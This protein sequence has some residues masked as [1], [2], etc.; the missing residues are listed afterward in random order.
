MDHDPGGFQLQAV[1]IGSPSCGMDDEIC[2][3]ADLRSVQR[4]S[5]H[6]IP[7]VP[8]LD[9][10]DGCSRL[11]IDAERLEPFHQP[12]DE[13]GVEVLEHPVAVLQDCDLR[14]RQCGDV[15]EL[16]SD[17]AAADQDDA[18]RQGFQREESLV[19]NHVLFAGNVQLDRLGPRCQYDVFCFDGLPGNL[20]HVPSRELRSPVEGVDALFSIGRLLPLR[21]GVREGALERHQLGPID[22][23]VADDTVAVHA[24]HLVD[25]RG[26]A[27]EHL[28]GIAAAQ[29]AGAAEGAEVDDRD[30]PARCAN[31]G[32]HT[33]RR[34]ARADDDQVVL[35][36]HRTFSCIRVGQD[37]RLAAARF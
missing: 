15:R 19:R 4:R 32:R 35:A 26:A 1:E 13:L 6:A 21:N 5:S 25:R 27:D 30:G 36:I 12:A 28:L 10:L 7:A 18:R 23:D 22:A 11:H 33:H 37:S 14:P 34:C 17:V 29:G 3:D 8:L 24:G 2:I 9:A 16:G 20:Q 31:P